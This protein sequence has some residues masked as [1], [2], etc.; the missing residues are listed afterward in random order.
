[1][2]VCLVGIAISRSAGAR[3]EELM[4]AVDP[5]YEA[6]QKRGREV[7]RWF[8]G[9]LGLV[10]AAIITFVAVVACVST[11]PLSATTRLGPS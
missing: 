7:D 9:C 4:R 1:M 8:L 2:V 10:V 3:H 5:Q 6:R 11:P